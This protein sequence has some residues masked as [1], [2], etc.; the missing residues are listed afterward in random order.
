MA[1]VQNKSVD[2]VGLEGKLLALLEHSTFQFICSLNNIYLY[3]IFPF[4]YDS[5]LLLGHINNLKKYV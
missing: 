2:Q 3:V 4:W 5:L 1:H